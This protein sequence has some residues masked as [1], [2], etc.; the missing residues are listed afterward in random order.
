MYACLRGCVHCVY[1]TFIYVCTCVLCLC[2]CVVCICVHVLHMHVYEFL[3][4]C[5]VCAFVCSHVFSFTRSGSSLH[6][7]DKR[8]WTQ[9]S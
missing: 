5:V 3:C 9:T 4:M 8:T 2:M 7:I 1:I 6:F